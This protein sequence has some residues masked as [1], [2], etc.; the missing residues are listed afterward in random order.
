[1]HAALEIAGFIQQRKLLFENNQK[2]YW[3]IRLG[4]H[5]GPVVA[6]V[7]GKHKFAYDIWGDTVNLASRMESHSLPGRVNVSQATYEHIKQEF[8]CEDRG[9]QEIKKLDSV[10]MYFANPLT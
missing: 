3:D 2:P 8:N 4:I 10:P 9:L 6:G 5:S 1:M 7:V